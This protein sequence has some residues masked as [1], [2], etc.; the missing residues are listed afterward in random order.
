M[1]FIVETGAGVANANAYIDDIFA[2]AHFGDR[3]FTI[4]VQLLLAEKQQAIV[5]ATD[6][7]GQMFSWAGERVNG[8]QAL[9][10]PRKG[11]YLHEVLIASN[12]IPLLLKQACA[13]IA[14]RAAAGPLLLDPSV[15]STGR[16][17]GKDVQ[18]VGPVE[19]EKTY[20]ARGQMAIPERYK[21]FPQVERM[22]APLVVSAGQEVYR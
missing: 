4:W 6:Y 10:W 13:E 12:S 7:M 21:R 15:D 22:L 5:R 1:A 11:V 17:L 18:R 8:A 3:G 19:T 14:I 2:D 20:I 16:L 9:D